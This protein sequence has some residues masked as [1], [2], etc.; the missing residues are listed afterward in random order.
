MGMQGVNEGYF[1]RWGGVNIFLL[2][3]KATILGVGFGV[4]LR[5]CAVPN[6]LKYGSGYHFPTFLESYL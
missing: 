1:I 2:F 6:G 4:G 5:H 3:K